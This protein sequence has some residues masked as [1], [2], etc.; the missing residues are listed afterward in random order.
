MGSEDLAL[1]SALG[2][3][4]VL[5]IPVTMSCSQAAVIRAGVGFLYPAYKSL[6]AIMSDDREASL[7]WMRYWVVLAVFSMIETIV[8]PLLDFLPGYLLGKCIF[9]VWCMAPS[10]NSGA[11]LLF[12]QIIFPLFKKHHE[13]IDQQAKIVHDSFMEK[14]GRYFYGKQ[15]KW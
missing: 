10:K 11:N 4:A 7:T 6:H 1:V 8:D 15:K 3:E 2:T 9:L 5:K 12:T 13:E 14:F